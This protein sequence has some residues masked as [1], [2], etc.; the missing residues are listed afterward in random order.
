MSGAVTNTLHTPHTSTD[1][2][3]NAALFP[4]E[5]VSSLATAEV[6]H[7]DLGLDVRPQQHTLHPVV[8]V[9]HVEDRALGR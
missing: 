8:E 5:Q 6:Q 3:S 2:I 4:L 9:A 1:E 7:S